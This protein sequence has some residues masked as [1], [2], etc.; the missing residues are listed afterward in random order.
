MAI[1]D[2][3]KLYSQLDLQPDCS[4]DDFKYAYRR[5]I[6]ELH[7]DR[8]GAA[9]GDGADQALLSD[10]SLT[11]A[12][13]IRFHKQHGRLP[14]GKP[15]PARSVPAGFARQALPVRESSRDKPRDPTVPGLSYQEKL[16]VLAA[17]ALA[18]MSLFMLL[19]Y[20]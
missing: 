18:L 16:A 8:A 4:L 6:G 20:L 9:P 5:R 3:L 2:F 7:P 17:V 13:A 1:P 19:E 12:A 10:L 11:Y 15:E 14:G